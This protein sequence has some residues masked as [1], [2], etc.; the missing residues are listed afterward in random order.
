[1]SQLSK[2]RVQLENQEAS[3]ELL[4]YYLDYA[5]DI[6]CELRNTTDVESQY[7]NVQIEIAIEKFNK[8]GVEGQISHSEN[9]LQRVYSSSDVS[10]EIINRIIP[11]AKTPWSTKRVI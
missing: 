8:R 2:L 9:G 4:Q 11:V 3:D 6:I 10:P 1:M 5:H 7:L